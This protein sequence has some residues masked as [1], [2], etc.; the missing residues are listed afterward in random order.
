M[1]PVHTLPYCFCKIHFN[2]CPYLSLVLYDN[3]FKLLTYNYAVLFCFLFLLCRHKCFSALLLRHTSDS[4]IMLTRQT[5]SQPSAHVHTVTFSFKASHLTFLS[6]I[7]LSGVKE[8]ILKYS[9]DKEVVQNYQLRKFWSVAVE[10]LSMANCVHRY[11]FYNSIPVV[12]NV[13]GRKQCFRGS[14]QQSLMAWRAHKFSTQS[15][16]WLTALPLHIWHSLMGII[17]Q[18]LLHDL[19]VL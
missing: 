19:A 18:W 11:Q 6:F 3:D 8:R 14:V 2:T 7:H 16:Q 12:K 1:N 5:A 15:L 9:C 4:A 10:S 13:T 17:I